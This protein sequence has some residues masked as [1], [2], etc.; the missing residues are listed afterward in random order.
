M[1]D[2]DGGY[3][4]FPP[5]TIGGPTGDY[6]VDAPVQSARWAEFSILSIC[7]GPTNVST[8]TVS[9][10]AAPKA[11]KFD[12]SVTTSDNAIIQGQ[13]FRLGADTTL[14]I[15][16]EYARMPNNSQKRLYVRID[17]AANT[18]TYVT[19]RFREKLL[20]TVPGP[21]HEVHPDHMQN[22]NKLR[23]ETIKQ[24]LQ[25]AGIPGYAQEDKSNGR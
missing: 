6:F 2:E 17:V 19:V 5:V 22:M 20:S 18:S 4:Y 13:I 25:E 24:R 1:I 11:Q 10:N 3:T 15:I 21:S 14:P 9:G 8:V 23:S 12:G 16:T 7:N